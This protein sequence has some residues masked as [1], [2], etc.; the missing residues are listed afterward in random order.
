MKPK[1]LLVEDDKDLQGIISYNFS[2]EGFEI[3]TCS[4]GELAME[5]VINENPDLI[6]LDWMLPNISGVEINPYLGAIA[7][8]TKKFLTLS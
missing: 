6:I 2:K 1:V 7:N 8:D 3:G 5:T 4:D